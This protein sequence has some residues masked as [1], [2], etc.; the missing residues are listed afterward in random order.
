MHLAGEGFYTYQGKVNGL[1]LKDYFS[2]TTLVGYQLT[3]KLQPMLLVKGATAPSSYSDGLL[4]A[5]ARVIWSLSGTTSLDLFVS[6][7]IADSSPE[8]GG[9]LAAI[10]SF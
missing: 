5:R 2:F 1:G 8:Y 7:G 6:H 4:E 3:E 10:Y 9:G